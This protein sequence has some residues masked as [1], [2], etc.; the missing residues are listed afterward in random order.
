[1]LPGPRPP[2]RARGWPPHPARAAAGE[3]VRREADPTPPSP[4]WRGPGRVPARRAP[5][6]GAAAPPKA[7]RRRAFSRR[8]ARAAPENLPE[9]E[10]AERIL[11]VGDQTPAAA[12]PRIGNVL[13]RQR[14]PGLP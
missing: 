11:H 4:G 10:I 1:M 7:A 5:R 14:D 2:R 12:Y 13:E 9:A 6:R 3:R 8:S